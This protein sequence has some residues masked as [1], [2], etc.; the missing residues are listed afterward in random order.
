MAERLRQ[1]RLGL[2]RED[3]R[4]TRPRKFTTD[5][6]STI[7]AGARSGT[8]LAPAYAKSRD[9]A[10][11]APDAKRLR[12]VRHND[13]PGSGRGIGQAGEISGAPGRSLEGGTSQESEL[14][15]K[16]RTQ[17]GHRSR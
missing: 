6:W 16:T 11:R 4:G 17:G 15:V 5:S 9:G 7:Y 10:K 1:C 13:R 2:F 12:Q 14:R 8:W 3:R